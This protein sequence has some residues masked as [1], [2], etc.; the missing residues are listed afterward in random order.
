MILNGSWVKHTGMTYKSLYIDNKLYYED[1][2]VCQPSKYYGLEIVPSTQPPTL[3]QLKHPEVA[4]LFTE[5]YVD[6]GSNPILQKYILTFLE[7]RFKHIGYSTQ[8][9]YI[10]LANYTSQSILNKPN[11]NEIP[12]NELFDI[13]FQNGTCVK[14]EKSCIPTFVYINNKA[15]YADGS[16]GNL[17]LGLEPKRVDP[18]PLTEAQLKHP[19]VAILFPLPNG[20][21]VATNYHWDGWA[22]CYN[23]KLFL[24]DGQVIDKT[25][26]ICVKYISDTFALTKK[27]LKHPEVIKYLQE[28][29]Q[30]TL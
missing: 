27:Q 25:P 5:R 16:V 19:E 15:Y 10:N 6:C 29:L 7:T 4:E 23:Q 26:D 20:I 12:I 9:Y 21:V 30:E 28:T 2:S 18:V 1:G 8:Y 22:V 14:Y 13:G 3:Q 24:P 17:S 11:V